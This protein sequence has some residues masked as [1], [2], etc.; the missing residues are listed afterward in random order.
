MELKQ[1]SSFELSAIPPYNFELTVHKPAGWYWLTPYEIYSKGVVWTGARLQSGE[2]VGMKLRSTGSLEEPKVSI[3]LFS[4]ERLSEA[5]E[6]EAAMLASDSLSAEEDVSEF[7]T[8]AGGHRVLRQALKDLYGMRDTHRPSLFDTAV[9]AITL[10]MAPMGRTMQMMTLLY[11][12]YG[13]IIEFDGRRVLLCPTPQKISE[14]GEGVLRERCKLGFRAGYIKTLSRRLV[15]SPLTLEDLKRMSPEEA[16]RELMSVRGIGEYSAEIIT[17]HPS[18]PVDIWSAKIFCT[19]FEIE[20]DREPREM[21]PTVKNYAREAF[22]EWQSYAFTY[23]LNDLENLS[24]ELGKAVEIER[25]DWPKL[26]S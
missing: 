12:N 6:K 7:N 24:E 11:E 22:G 13:E 17:P 5:E 20:M 19:L 25:H 9:L 16:K 8:L 14:V 23:I 1:V 10:Q 3:T 15:E 26:D 4:G 21:I 18:F 2:S